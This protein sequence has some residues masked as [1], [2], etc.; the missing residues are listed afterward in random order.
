VKHFLIIS[1]EAYLLHED[2]VPEGVLR[3]AEEGH[4]LLLDV[5]DP[6]YP[7]RYEDGIWEDV[8]PFM[9]EF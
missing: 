5:T 6:M 7:S 9:G 8:E 2:E 1:E 4:F 3:A